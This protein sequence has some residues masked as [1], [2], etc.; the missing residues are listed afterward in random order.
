MPPLYYL[1]ESHNIPL[2]LM[3]LLSHFIEK[4]VLERLSNFLKAMLSAKWQ[5]KDSMFPDLAIL[6]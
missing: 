4:Q 1:I 6:L 2:R 3:L 5:S